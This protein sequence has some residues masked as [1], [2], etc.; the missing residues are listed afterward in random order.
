MVRFYSGTVLICLCRDVLKQYDKLGYRIFLAK[1]REYWFD[2][3]KLTKERC[4]QFFM[5]KENFGPVENT[6]M[7]RQA[8]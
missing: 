3:G 8:G 1:F 2:G 4:E 5:T 7:V 6:P